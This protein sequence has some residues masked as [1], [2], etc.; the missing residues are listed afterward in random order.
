LKK[1]PIVCLF[2]IGPAAVIDLRPAG[3]EPCTLV[4]PFSLA[5]VISEAT[6]PLQT[7]LLI[8]ALQFEPAYLNVG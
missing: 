1:K 7:T 3:D 2:L 4:T 8:F 6:A 5:G